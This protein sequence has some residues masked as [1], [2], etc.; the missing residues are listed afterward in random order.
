MMMGLRGD[1]R[2]NKEKVTAWRGEESEG[3]TK[4]ERARFTADLESSKSQARVKQNGS[5][6]K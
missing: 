3:L 2:G 5:Y 6:C 1:L 4:K